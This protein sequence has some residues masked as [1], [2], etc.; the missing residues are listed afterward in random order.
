MTARLKVAFAAVITQ[1]D[2]PPHV[3][4]VKRH[5]DEI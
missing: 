5:Q 2:G 3:D 1:R 4:H